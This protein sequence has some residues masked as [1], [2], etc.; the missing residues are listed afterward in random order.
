MLL[1][2][3]ASRP[4]IGLLIAGWA[5][6]VV[7]WFGASRGWRGPYQRETADRND[8][9]R[10]IRQKSGMAALALTSAMVALQ[11]DRLWGERGAAKVGVA[12]FAGLFVLCL[13]GVGTI[14]LLDRPRWA[15]PP[16][17]RPRH[18]RPERA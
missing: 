9:L 1:E 11:I 17:L 16:D 5:L 12:V 8:R 4:S 18:H 13:V 7:S 14:N 3:G 6:V 15:I 2:I 10:N